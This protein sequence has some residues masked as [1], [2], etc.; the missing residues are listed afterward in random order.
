[1]TTMTP[2]RT[3]VEFSVRPRT[4]IDLSNEM[5]GR[6]LSAL[7]DALSA[8]ERALGPSPAYDPDTH[9]LSAVFQVELANLDDASQL[10]RA[11]AIAV[12]IFARAL[13]V[14]GVADAHVDGVSVVEGDDPDQLP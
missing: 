9:E 7:L 12:N 13:R 1:M 2:T 6:T 10:E 4:T 8:D 3:T 11:S 14:A 5:D